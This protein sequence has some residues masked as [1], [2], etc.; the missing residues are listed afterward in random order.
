DGSAMVLNGSPTSI[1][2]SGTFRKTGGT[3]V[4]TIGVAFNNAG[5]ADVQTGTLALTGGGTNSGQFTNSSAASV[6]RFAG[7]THTLLDT[8]SISGP[9]V[10]S[11]T[12]GTLN[13]QCNLAVA[14]LTNNGSLNFNTLNSAYVTNLTV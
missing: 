1:A 3:G 7:G 5:L 13:V 14:T 8:A 11:I 6:L 4:S 9:G 12:T 2:N 10:V